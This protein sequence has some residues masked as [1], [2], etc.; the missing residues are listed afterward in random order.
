M[1]L[2]QAP[3]KTYIHSTTSAGKKFE[4]KLRSQFDPSKIPIERV[5]MILEQASRKS[6][7]IDEYRTRNVEY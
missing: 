5:R 6:Q 7:G 4:V 1:K 3:P 2:L